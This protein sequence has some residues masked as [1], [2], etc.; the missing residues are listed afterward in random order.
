MSDYPSTA[1]FFISRNPERL[2]TDPILDIKYRRD[3]ASPLL[4][5]GHTWVIEGY[6]P[7]YDGRYWFNRAD[8]AIE[9]EYWDTDGGHPSKTTYDSLA[10]LLDHLETTFQEGVPFNRP[11]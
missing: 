5:F 11:D 6:G 3:S 4:H 1:R 2:S 8:V 7:E 10:A 9:H